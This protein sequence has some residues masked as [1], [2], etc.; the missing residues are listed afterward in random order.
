MGVYRGNESARVLQYRVLKNK[1]HKIGAG[2]YWEGVPDPAELLRELTWQGM[3]I[4]GP[5][6]LHVYKEQ[7]VT[8]PLHVAT[9]RGVK[10]TRF[11]RFHRVRSTDSYGYMGLCLHSAVFAVAYMEDEA[12]IEL[13]EEAYKG[14]NG[15][16]RL[17][18][19]TRKLPNRTR[20]LI[21]QAA[22]GTDS[23]AEK[24]LIYALRGAGLQCTNNVLIGDY[25]WDIKVGNV[26]I[27]VDGYAHHGLMAE[28]RTQFRI[29]RW[30]ANDAALRGFIVLRYSARCV[31]DHER[32]IVEQ[33]KTAVE[34]APKILPNTLPE[35]NE[36]PM[37]RRG[38]WK[39]GSYWDLD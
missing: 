18:N 24:N 33:I 27:E 21:A 23:P 28:N 26:L 4:T 34:C 13:L 8:F 32:I 30:K 1:L 17:E 6:Q 29:D 2:I 37:W 31:F 10:S 9:T 15:L 3:M 11:V 20:R 22:V 19:T 25:R 39:W 7:P 16:E 5:T 36:E 35:I 14:K 38:F 12:A